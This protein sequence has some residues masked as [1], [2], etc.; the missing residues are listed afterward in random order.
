M[1]LKQ[2][3]AGN[4]SRLRLAHGW[5]QAELA[6]KLNY[7]DK[8][9]SKWERGESIPDV[10]ILKQISELFHISLDDLLSEPRQGKEEPEWEKAEERA[11]RED[12][13]ARRKRER[14]ERRAARQPKNEMERKRANTKHMLISIVSMLG[15]FVLAFV[16][17]IIVWSATQTVYWMI[18]IYSLP[19][20][21][22]LCIIFNSVW[23]N[24]KLVGNWISIS[25]FILSILLCVYLQLIQY[26]LWMLFLIMIPVEV[27]MFFAFWLSGLNKLFARKSGKQEKKSDQENGKNA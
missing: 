6:E 12:R 17:M 22:L 23:G 15:V 19:V 7:S 2:I 5:T 11:E 16:V 20:I 3:F 8:T 1:E 4:L 21:F 24:H 14:E 27:L 18:L 13:K 10:S 26:D 25:L 9:V